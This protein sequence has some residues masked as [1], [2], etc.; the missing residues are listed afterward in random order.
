MA[1]SLDLEVIAEGVE[2]DEQLAFLRL[3]FCDNVQGYLVSYPISA[4]AL[5]RVLNLNENP[6]QEKPPIGTL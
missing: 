2:K 1:R 4:S 5:N 6:G 3:Q